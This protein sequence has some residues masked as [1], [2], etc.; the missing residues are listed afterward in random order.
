M[1]LA[2]DFARNV[3]ETGSRI[4][5]VTPCVKLRVTMSMKSTTLTQCQMRIILI[6]RKGL[7]IN[8]LRIRPCPRNVYR[9]CFVDATGPVAARDRSP[10]PSDVGRRDAKKN[11]WRG[12][13]CPP[14]PGPHRART[15]PRPRTTSRPRHGDARDGRC[16]RPGPVDGSAP[17]IPRT[18]DTKGGQVPLQSQPPP[19]RV[20]NRDR[21]ILM[22]RI[23]A[24]CSQVPVHRD[25]PGR[26]TVPCTVPSPTLDGLVERPPGMSI[27]RPSHH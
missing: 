21:P 24:P 10:V 22:Y 2:T 16:T 1:F 4:P 8:G 26:R 19:A 11:E 27:V 14:V 12:Y 20:R 7:R 13:P 18:G 5:R 9:S 17:P 6:W 3:T 23:P 25:C 15:G